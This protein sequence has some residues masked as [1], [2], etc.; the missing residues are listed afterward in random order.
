M[1]E[2]YQITNQ[3]ARYFLTLRVVKWV[4][5]F[6]RQIYRDIVLDCLKYCIHHKGLVL[7]SYVIMTNHLHLIVRSDVGRISDTIRDFKSYTAKQILEAIDSNVESR[8]DWML[9]RFE[10]SAR[11]NR[12][13]SLHQFWKHGN[14]A[15][16]LDVPGLVRQKCHYIHQNPVRAGFVARASDW[17]YSSA[18][19]YEGEAG[20]IN[21]Y[22]LEEM[23]TL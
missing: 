4:D 10:F 22:L 23:Y 11:R 13:N 1:S 12:R 18:A 8:R 15:I 9:K 6:S 19:N 3:N 17:L 2:G 21:V 7:Y 16:F 5:V 14:H 20:L